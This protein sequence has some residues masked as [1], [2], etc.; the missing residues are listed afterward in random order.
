MNLQAQIDQLKTSLESLA[1]ALIV[2]ADVEH[3]DWA[4]R[5]AQAL[6]ALELVDGQRG[7]DYGFRVARV[8]GLVPVVAV[9]HADECHRRIRTYWLGINEQIDPVNYNCPHCIEQRMGAAQ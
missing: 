3:Y 6:D 1:H 7:R 2:S 5:I 4:E 8:V 9:I